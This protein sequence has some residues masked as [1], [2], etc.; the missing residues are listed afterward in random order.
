MVSADMHG[1]EN[2][3][4]DLITVGD[5]VIREVGLLGL[6]N[7]DETACPS[8][9][10]SYQDALHCRSSIRSET[11]KSYPRSIVHD[12][13]SYRLPTTMIQVSWGGVQIVSIDK[14]TAVTSGNN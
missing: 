5:L 11:G 14:D 9:H 3:R 13:K 1:W 12:R 4:T 10:G 7:A 8:S 6:D 2:Q